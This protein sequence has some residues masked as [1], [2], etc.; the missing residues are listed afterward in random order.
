VPTKILLDTDIGSDIDDAV[1]LA[2]LLAQ[3]ECELLGITTVTG[4]ARKRAMMASALCKLAGKDV[5]IFPG[6]EEPLL[7]DQKQTQAPQAAA[8]A[9]WDHDEDFPSGHAVE[10]LRSTIRENPGETV[11]L[12]IGPLTNVALL[13]KADPEIPSLLKGLVM[14]CGVYDRLPASRHPRWGSF[15]VSARS[16][17]K[18]RLFGRRLRGIGLTEWN[19]MLDPHATAMVYRANVTSHRS[20]GL[21]VTTRVV[22]DAESVRRRF[23]HGLLRP[24]LDFAEVWFERPDSPWIMFHD[25]RAATTIFDGRIC[26]FERG[27]V[28]V[29]LEDRRQ[30]G[31]TRWTAGTGP[32]KHEVALDVDSERFFEHYFSVF[33]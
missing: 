32:A 18:M 14:M 11:L 13:F 23:S 10:F 8:L 33:E 25:P 15:S 19:A 26:S 29:E 12:T 1:C 28:N 2:Y 3:P 24:V 31:R 9:K 6:A 21:D 22:M 16:L 7:V 5:P 30:L 20:I 17:I 27:T 4:E